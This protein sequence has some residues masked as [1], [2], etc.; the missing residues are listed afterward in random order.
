LEVDLEQHVLA[1]S[2][3]AAVVAH[4]ERAA[5][6][7]VANFPLAPVTPIAYPKGLDQHARY[8]APVHYPVPPY[9]T[10]VKLGEEH[11][12]HR[13]P[14][15]D[16]HTIRWY[17]EARDVVDFCSWTPCAS[18]PGRLGYA[19][20]ILS[21]RGGATHEHVALA[22]VAVHRVL[23]DSGV[24]AI[25][26]LDGFAGAALF[27][28]FNDTPDY[29]AVRA[30]LHEAAETAVLRNDDL[31]TSDQHD[32]KTQRVHVNVGSNA[33]GRYSSLPYALTGGP[34]L[35]MVTPIEWGE[36]NTVVNGHYTALNSAER[37]ARG[38][39]FGN[40]AADLV[41]QAFGEG[42]H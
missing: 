10:T 19:R 24:D 42:P 14:A 21:P 41:D 15:L 35:G 3:R 5:P 16:K 36:L 8:D 12:H 22:M 20:I 38:D 34:N 32:Q 30:W 33:V 31:L 4:Y 23:V 37:L 40:A 6:L 39:V 27:I 13:Y 7:I 29:S 28:P 17:T 11:Q 26:V 18:D 9:V 25:P 1:P 2:V